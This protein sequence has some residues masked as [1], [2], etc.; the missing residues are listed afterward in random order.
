M[1]YPSN[2][3]TISLATNPL[4]FYPQI[5]LNSPTFLLYASHLHANNILLIIADDL[6]VDSHGLYGIGSSVAPTPTIDSLAVQGIRFDRAWSNPVCSPTRATILTGRYSFRT[7]VGSPVKNHS[8]TGT[9][10]SVADALKSLG[11]STAQIGKWHL[12]KRTSSQPNRLGFDHYSGDLGGALPDYFN[13]EKTE[14]GATSTVTTYAT[15]ENVDDAIA[16]IG[17][18]AIQSPGKPWFIWLAFNAPHWPYHKPP[19]VLH[20]YDYLPGTS[21]DIDENPVQYYQAMVEAMDTEI[22]RL[23]NAIDRSNTNI[24]FV[25][26]NGTPVE[27]SVAV[28]PADPKRVKGTLYQG[29]V[30]VPLIISGPIVNQKN[31]SNAALVNTTD[32]FATIIEM[33]G[34]KV[35]DLAPPGTV[36]DSVSLLPILTDPAQV[37]LC[38]YVFAEQFH[39]PLNNRDGKTIRNN[40]YKLI[41]FDLGGERLYKLSN[42][43][44]LYPTDEDDNL[45]DG[46]LSATEQA[47]YDDLDIKINSLLSGNDTD[48]VCFVDFDLD[49]VPDSQDNCPDDPNP[50]QGNYDNDA[51]GD[52]CDNDDDN[53]G[54]PDVIDA[55][56][57]DTDNDGIDNALDDDDDNDGLPDNTDPLP[58]LYNWADGNVAP[59][60]SPDSTVNAADLLVMLQ[61]VLGLKSPTDNDLAHGDVYPIGAPDGVINLSDVIAVQKMVLFEP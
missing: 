10:Y 55:Y 35:S 25:G 60:G 19:N 15:T 36:I 21:S 28:P 53:D 56:P 31:R 4:Y 51:T 39:D 46:A 20:S 7:G 13:W 47:N 11:Y 2:L 17:E 40:Q 58:L 33:A 27:G 32:L 49:Q 61:F 43:F 6:G 52:A 26:D 14:D 24:I 50:D 57:F 29:G 41:R 9:E 54:I 1:L 30:W 48:R 44:S 42:D 38:Q 12:G 45:L 23:L 3:K 8:I 5:F 22:N 59:W 34:G 37:D 16:W 18:Q